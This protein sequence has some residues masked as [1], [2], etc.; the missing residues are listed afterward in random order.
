MRCRVL[1]YF[2]DFFALK[3]AVIE[4]QGLDGVEH[5]LR[6]NSRA[7][8]ERKCGKKLEMPSEEARDEYWKR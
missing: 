2:W 6:H 1:S 8:R 5:L 7:D 4:L 3:D